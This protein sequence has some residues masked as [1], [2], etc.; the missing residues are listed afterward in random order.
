MADE[1][2]GEVLSLHEFLS[3]WLTGQ[4]DLSERVFGR[5]ANALADDFNVIHPNGL[6]QDKPAVL[7]NFREAYGNKPAGF[8][9]DISSVLSRPLGNGLSLVIYQETHVGDPGRSRVCSALIRRLPNRR[10]EW[11]HLHETLKQQAA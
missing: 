3:Q 2:T 7:K 8:R 6:M 5:F 11:L 1:F 9:L 10:F 4:V